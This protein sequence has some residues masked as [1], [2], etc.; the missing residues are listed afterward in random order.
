MAVVPMNLCACMYVCVCACV[1]VCCV[2]VCGCVCVC[3]CVCVPIHATQQEVKN[4][5]ANLLSWNEGEQALPVEAGVL[6]LSIIKDLWELVG[7]VHLVPRGCVRKVLVTE[8]AGVVSGRTLQAQGH[9]Q[10]LVVGREPEVNP[11]A[12]FFEDP[13]PA[14]SSELLVRSTSTSSCESGG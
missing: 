4:V 5:D 11:D 14:A 7:R 9:R 2:C 8:N 12:A 3:V 10:E 6:V 13:P 1:C